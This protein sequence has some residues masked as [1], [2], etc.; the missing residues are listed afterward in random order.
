L[1]RV[2]ID[3]FRSPVWTVSGPNS[4]LPSKSQTFRLSIESVF[5]GPPLTRTWTVRAGSG[6]PD[7]FA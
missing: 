3:T 6:S 5:G 4:I 7:V 2:V 1:P